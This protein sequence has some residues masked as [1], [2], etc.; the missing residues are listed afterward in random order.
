MSAAFDVTSSSSEESSASGSNAPKR[1]LRVLV[2]DDVADNR[3]VLTR[4]L[5]RRDFEVTEADGGRSA[6]E[7]I[8]AGE[9]DVILLDIMMPDIL[10]SE[11]LRTI[12][13][14][15]SQTELPVIMV[16][17]KSESEDVVRCL[18]LG[19]NDYVTKP[20]DFAVA[21]ARINTQIARKHAAENVISRAQHLETAVEHQKANL[22]K[23]EADLAREA[24][25][26]RQSD[27]RLK[28]LAF[29]D[30]LTGLLNRTAFRDAL[31]EV[32]G[33]PDASASALVFL[34]LD[35]FK[36]VNDERGH[37]T[38][39]KLLEGIAGRLRQA[40]G[41]S[42]VI[43]RLGGDEFAAIVN[44]SRS[45]SALEI[46]TRAIAHIREPFEI[47]EQ[48]FQIG[49]SCGVARPHEILGSVD[50]LIN[51]ADL[52]MYFA[53]STGR[54]KI[55]QF[56]P[57]ML[58][59][60]REKRLLEAELRIAIRDGAFEVYYQ[61]LV[62]AATGNLVSF[63]ALVRWNHPTRGV[64]APD[65][66]IPL[67]E[68]TG[69]IVSLGEWVLRQACAEAT[70]WPEE[71]RVAVNLSPL[72][73]AHKNLLG[74]IVNTL[75][76]TGLAPNRLELEITESAL[77]GTQ[78]ENFE[79]LRAI[80]DLGVRVSMDDFGTGYSSMSYLQNFKFDKIKIDRS[81]IR[82]LASDP[83]SF[84]IIKAIVELGES[85]GIATTAEGVET[86]DQ[87]AYITSQ[88]CTEAQGYF[89]SR[90]LTAQNARSF[91]EKGRIADPD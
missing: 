25:Q 23:A 80:R 56:E 1:A 2:V 18:E 38:G 52:A 11:V 14:T 68:E 79:L 72:Q 87:L 54:G 61:P 15:F 12:R 71:L 32:L 34:D 55:A 77:L 4:R 70:N 62:A 30:P 35:N 59:E 83:S 85:I 40:F 82:D 37:E 5:V 39:D 3:D 69:L 26:R 63:E 78:S 53:K 67:A 49:A 73:F 41:A 17:A 42:A 50:E 29:H 13:E 28:F 76:K 44:E 74:I 19:A 27:D 51:A 9:F 16:S 88:G 48:T 8:R 22:S 75:A 6:L 65:V 24:D 47:F 89:F 90:P 36:T 31:K 33:S 10:G 86:A 91:I 66:F 81:F 20:V 7:A 84:A 60:Q 57:R 46:G 21:L 45:G 64:V 58:T 43:G